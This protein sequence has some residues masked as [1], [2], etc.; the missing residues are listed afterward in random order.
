MYIY[1]YIYSTWHSCSQQ[2]LDV[3]DV[4]SDAIVLRAH[5]NF[6]SVVTATPCWVIDVAD[7]LPSP[8]SKNK[9]LPATYFALQ[10]TS[11]EIKQ[12]VRVIGNH[13][14][15]IYSH[16]SRT[17][18]HITHSHTSRTSTHHVYS[19]HSP[20]H[21]LAHIMYSHTS[22]ARTHHVLAHSTYSHHSHHV[23]AHIMYSHTLH[24]RINHVLAH[25]RSA[26]LHNWV[27]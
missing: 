16:T 6:C 13:W 3:L 5:V 24:T 18:A 11:V 15:H 21:V 19:H 8:D 20:H 7:M 27:I 9:K 12:L 14:H 25:I 23:L 2:V 22:C 1:I 10:E 17:I 4:S 26:C